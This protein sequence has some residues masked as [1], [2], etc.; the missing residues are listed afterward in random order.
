MTSDRERLERLL[1]GALLSAL[2]ARLRRRFAR[3][4]MPPLLTLAR[5]A[6][7]ERRA[8]EGLLGRRSREADSLRMSVA[9]LDDAVSRAGLATSFR[10]ALE[11]L[12]GPIPDLLALRAAQERAWLDAYARAEDSRLCE[13]LEQ[14]AARGLVRR[15]ALGKPELA[16][17]WLESA[18]R[19]LA[20][21][22]A[23]GSPRSRLAADTLGDA[24]ALDRG[25][26]VATLTLAA[27]RR[28]ED[29][30]D[31]EIWARHG[32]LVN[33]L[34]APAL[35]LNLPAQRDTPTGQLASTAR[36]LGVPLHFTLR[37]LLREAPRWC[38]QGRDVFVC[39]NA[40]V[41]SIAADRLGTG[42]APL[43]CTDGMPSASQR[44]LLQQLKAQGATLRY[45]GDFD[46][47]GLRIANFVM[48]SFGATA[49]RL[50]SHDYAARP[51]RAL[52]GDVVVAS[53][54]A[55]LAPR[56]AAGG[57]ALEEEAVVEVLLADLAAGGAPTT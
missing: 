12:D 31:R 45:H 3:E 1:G 5:L 44:V 46:W 47:P 15:L 29:E 24:H 41:V 19:V 11:L 57:Y 51:G 36:E 38:I 10:H 13:F 22:P 32:V 18:T 43:I 14:G 52:S 17:Q 42:C 50:G 21:L 23:P 56:M 55:E 7:H 26:P 53:W 49:W 4:P 16:A 40:N 30:R 54:D 33:E 6:T 20:R 27:L 35:V 8:L 25:R 9:E 39:E 34:A 48:R 37:A 2:R 28:D